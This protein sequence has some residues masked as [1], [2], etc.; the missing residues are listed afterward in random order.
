MGPPVPWQP[1]REEI[2]CPY[3]VK[4]AR[5]EADWKKRTW[6]FWSVRKCLVCEDLGRIRKGGQLCRERIVVYG[7]I[8]T[9]LS[10]SNNY[11][12]EESYL[13]CRYTISGILV[14][15]VTA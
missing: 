14:L 3:Y 5:S 4:C 13:T 7:P 2:F 6:V 9:R 15:T 8:W 10:F 12:G 1:N 11:I